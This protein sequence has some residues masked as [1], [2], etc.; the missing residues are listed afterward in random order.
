[1]ETILYRHN[2]LTEIPVNLTSVSKNKTAIFSNKLGNFLYHKIK[3]SLFSG[4]E[5]SEESGFSLMRATKAKAIFDFLYLRKNILPNR[6]AVKELRLNIRN[7]SRADIKE[8]EKYVALEGSKKIKEI[9]N[10][11]LD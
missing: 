6:E 1:L 3:S 8:L 2:I 11:L 5:L 9:L 7:L 10:Y 4:F